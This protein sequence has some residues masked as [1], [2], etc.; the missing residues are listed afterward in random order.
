[1]KQ[2]TCSGRFER[3]LKLILHVTQLGTTL[4]RLNSQFR[5]TN[6]IC[7]LRSKWVFVCHQVPVRCERRRPILSMIQGVLIPQTS[8]KGKFSLGRY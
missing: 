6:Q 1:M 7:N 2:Y 4:K 3:R 5:T 8:V